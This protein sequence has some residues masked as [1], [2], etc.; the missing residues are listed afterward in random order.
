MVRAEIKVS[1]KRQ[2]MFKRLSGVSISFLGIAKAG[3]SDHF[4]YWLARNTSRQKRK[5]SH[6]HVSVQQTEGVAVQVPWLNVNTEIEPLAICTYIFKWIN[7]WITYGLTLRWNVR[8][9]AGTNHSERSMAAGEPSRNTSK[10]C[11]ASNSK[12]NRKCSVHRRLSRACLDVVA[13]VKL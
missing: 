5:A 11:K 1:Q 12:E 9:L 7:H 6:G 13:A 8:I 10:K 4:Y 2:Q 3:D